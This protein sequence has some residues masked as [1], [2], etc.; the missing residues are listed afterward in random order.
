MHVKRRLEQLPTT[1]VTYSWK[2]VRQFS[3]SCMSMRPSSSPLAQAWSV[4]AM[5]YCCCTSA[6]QCQKVEG[7]TWPAATKM[8]RWVS[9]RSFPIS[10]AQASVPL[11]LIDRQILG[12][13]IRCSNSRFRH[14]LRTC[15][16][17]IWIWVC[18]MKTCFWVCIWTWYCESESV[19]FA[20]IREW[21]QCLWIYLKPSCNLRLCSITKSAPESSL[22]RESPLISWRCPTLVICLRKWFV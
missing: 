12:V 11:S 1:P 20:A 10:V 22:R 21:E 9:I 5:Y 3:K 18:M 6:L 4:V 19:M 17:R 2:T 16:N 13:H 7:R 8:T 14:V 15:S